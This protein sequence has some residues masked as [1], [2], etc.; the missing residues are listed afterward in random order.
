R[1]PGRVRFPEL[2][3]LG[4]HGLSVL[5]VPGTFAKAGQGRARARPSSFLLAWLRPC[6]RGKGMQ[7]GANP[8]ETNGVRVPHGLGKW[9]DRKEIAAMNPVEARARLIAPLVTPANLVPNAVRDISVALNILLA[10]M[11]TL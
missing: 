9:G 7:I 4:F 6:F 2:G 5:T 8:G 11:F 10:D 3:Q 1:Q